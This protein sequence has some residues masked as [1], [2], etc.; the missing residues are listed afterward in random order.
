MYKSQLWNPHISRPRHQD[1]NFSIQAT[2]QPNPTYHSQNNHTVVGQY[3]GLDHNPRTQNIYGL[4]SYRIITLWV[5]ITQNIYGLVSLPPPGLRHVLQELSHLFAP[6]WVISV[7][8]LLFVNVFLRVLSVFLCLY[9]CLF[10]CK[11]TP[12][13]G[14]CNLTQRAFTRWPWG[15]LTRAV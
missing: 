3:H 13:T 1:T 14:Q 8:C 12:S 5:G 2:K 7:F 9:M 11:V 6:P 4:Y 15:N 10:D